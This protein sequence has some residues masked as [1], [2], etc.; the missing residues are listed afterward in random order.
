M[1]QDL[2]HGQGLEE[3]PGVEERCRA[4][5][6][7]EEEEVALNAEHLTTLLLIVP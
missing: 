2:R 4:T 5:E 7:E 1:N 3:D 6:A